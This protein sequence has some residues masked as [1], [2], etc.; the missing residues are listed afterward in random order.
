MG[1]Y[2]KVVTYLMSLLTAMVLLPT[3]ALAQPTDK[4]IALARP[5]YHYY[6]NDYSPYYYGEQPSYAY[7]YTYYNSYGDGYL[8]PYNNYN[9]PYNGY[10]LQFRIR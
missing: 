9:Y 1:D 4:Q 8:N 3:A 5:Y 10:Y 2:W 6:Y 7:P